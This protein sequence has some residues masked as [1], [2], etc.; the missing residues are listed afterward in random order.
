MF[1]YSKAPEKKKDYIC[2]LYQRGDNLVV[3]L[4]L[5]N[6]T[7]YA[8]IIEKAPGYIQEAFINEFGSCNHC[9]ENCKHRKTYQI[10][11]KEY[12]KCDGCTFE[13]Y[14]LGVDSIPYYMDLLRLS[15]KSKK[16]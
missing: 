6:V 8:T 10:S 15:N 12:S 4:Y 9:K 1:A 7:S 13:F 16:A 5:K 3:R 14:Y 2:R 11:G